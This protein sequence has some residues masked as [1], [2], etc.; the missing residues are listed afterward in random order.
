MSDITKQDLQNLEQRITGKVVDQGQEL[1]EEIK[2]LGTELSSEIKQQTTAI[3]EEMKQ[4]GVTLRSEIKQQGVE[5]RKEIR[6][7]TDEVLEVVAQLA[8]ASHKQ[9][10]QV[11]AKS[12]DIEAEVIEANR[13]I[14]LLNSD[15]D[16]AFKNK[17]ITEDETVALFAG[18][19]RLESN[20]DLI[21]KT[22]GL[23]LPVS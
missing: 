8:E 11:H 9:F 2:Q 20:L 16:R 3:R 19:R 10:S 13:Q 6:S 22:I 1:R 12:E 7:A 17:S 23:T 21:A 14:N 18:Q 5:L 15:I 4:Q